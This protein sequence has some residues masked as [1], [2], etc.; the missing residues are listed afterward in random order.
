MILADSDELDIYMEFDKVSIAGRVMSIQDMGKVSFAYIQD[1]TDKIQIYIKIF[2][3]K[4]QCKF[5][6][7]YYEDTLK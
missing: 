2:S 3:Q 5:R 1:G 6:C 7:I 4:L